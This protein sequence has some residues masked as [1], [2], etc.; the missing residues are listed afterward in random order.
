M[1]IVACYFPEF[2][3][4]ETGR[5]I[6]RKDPDF[7][8]FFPLPSSLTFL[9]PVGTR[10]KLSDI[11]QKVEGIRKEFIDG[12]V[13]FKVSGIEYEPSRDANIVYLRLVIEAYFD[14][15]IT[16]LIKCMKEKSKMPE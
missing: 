7:C 10:I 12:D 14:I 3:Y 2:D 4:S 15:S 5:E 6:C 1:K 9:L 11:A 16:S 13:W 8:F